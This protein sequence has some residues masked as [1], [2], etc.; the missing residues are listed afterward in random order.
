MGEDTVTVDVI[1]EGA[2]G[3]TVDPQKTTGLAAL[4]ERLEVVGVVMRIESPVGEGTTV[5]I[6]APRV[7]PW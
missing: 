7:P 4:A 6:C 3:A 5:Q 1:D 2:G